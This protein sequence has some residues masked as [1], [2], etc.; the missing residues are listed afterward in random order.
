VEQFNAPSASARLT[1]AF[2]T[3][4]GADRTVL[5]VDAKDRRVHELRAGEDGVFRAQHSHQIAGGDLEN[6]RLTSDG[7]SPRLLSLGKDRFEVMPLGG[8]V[9]TLKVEATFE[10][11]LKDTL[12]TDL[13]AAPF[14]GGNPFDDLLL[15]DATRSR[16]LELF[17]TQRK[18][19][20]HWTSVLYFSVFQSDPNYRGKKGYEFEPHD[21]TVLDLNRDGRP[22]LCLLVHD[23][24][25]FYVQEKVD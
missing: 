4:N 14:V 2:V 12:P 22:D 15:V 11:E 13:I 20:H 18:G 6:C 24:V 5:L 23:R 7:P 25:L 9:L 19:E 1:A 3:G 17:T 16:V 21:Y 10:S 8:Q